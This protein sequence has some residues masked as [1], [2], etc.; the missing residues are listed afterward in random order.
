MTKTG[1]S[2]LD[3]GLS[4]PRLRVRVGWPAS[5]AFF[6]GFLG[7]VPYNVLIFYWFRNIPIFRHVIMEAQSSP[8]NGWEL[9]LNLQWFWYLFPFTTLSIPFAVLAMARIR[10][11]GERISGSGGQ[12]FLMWA[13]IA[14]AFALLLAVLRVSQLLLWSDFA[15]LF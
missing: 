4:L 14:C 2:T 12:R 11:Y 3:K 9:L 5:V 7:Y 6:L 15:I 1:P 10:R 13:W 8:Q